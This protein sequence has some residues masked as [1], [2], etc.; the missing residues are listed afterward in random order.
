MKWARLMTV[1]TVV[2]SKDAEFDKT[3]TLTPKTVRGVVQPAEKKN[4]NPDIVDWALEYTW[5]HTVN[6]NISNG[7]IVIGDRFDHL[8]VTYKVVWTKD[9]SEYGY[10]EAVGE[11]LV[12]TP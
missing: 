6:N 3:V 1:N 12:E 7:V 8:G 9:Y 2:V 5:L 10:Y 11:E 4:L